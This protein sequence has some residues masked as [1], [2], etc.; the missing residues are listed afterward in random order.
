MQLTNSVTLKSASYKIV[1]F[2]EGFE[3]TLKTRDKRSMTKSCAVSFEEARLLA[4]KLRNGFGETADD[5]PLV[6]DFAH[7][8]EI[9]RLTERH[10]DR[11][12][13]FVAY[14]LLRPARLEALPLGQL[15]R[16]KL[17]IDRLCQVHEIPAA[18]YM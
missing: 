5:S 11:E 2:T 15:D 6:P 7:N 14:L 18:L 8:P 1:A 10:D 12:P 9:I 3:K 17:N 4:R 13:G 16:R